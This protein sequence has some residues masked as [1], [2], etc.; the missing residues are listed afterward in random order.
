MFWQR[1]Q[2]ESTLL[3]EP[4]AQDPRDPVHAEHF[5]GQPLG[6]VALRQPHVAKGY[7]ATAGRTAVINRVTDGE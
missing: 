5:C 1:C 2:H 3:V 4:L 7:A 6:T